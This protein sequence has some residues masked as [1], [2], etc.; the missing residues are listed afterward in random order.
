MGKLFQKFPRKGEILFSSQDPF[1]ANNSLRQHRT[2]LIA[3]MRRQIF[4]Q[5]DQKDAGEM[6]FRQGILMQYD[7]KDASSCVIKATAANCAVLP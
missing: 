1:R 7:G 6:D 3:Q 5:T 4:R 2:I